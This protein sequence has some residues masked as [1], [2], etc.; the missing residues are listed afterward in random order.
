M[1]YQ[2]LFKKNVLPNTSIDAA[3]LDVHV[4]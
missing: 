4:K 2:T 3:M 1:Y